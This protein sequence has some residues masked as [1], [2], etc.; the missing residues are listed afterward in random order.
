[1]HYLPKAQLR[2]FHL[3]K[4]M[5]ERTIG[6]PLQGCSVMVTR[7]A[8]LADKLSDLCAQQGATVIRFPCM[9]I[10]DT[11]HQVANYNHI[12]QLNR[13]SLLIFISRNAVHYGTRLLHK[14]GIYQINI[15][16][17]AVG[18]KT[19]EALAQAGLPN[20]IHRRDAASSEALAATQFIKCLNKGSVLIFRGCGGSPYLG[21]KLTRQG[22]TVDYAEV[23]RRQKPKAS[24]R[25]DE[26]HSCPDI[27]TVASGETLAN[28]HAMTVASSISLLLD[29]QL[30]L[31]S[32]SMKAL[33][34]NLG[35]KHKPVIARSPID[36]DMF[37]AILRHYNIH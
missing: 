17:A 36:D 34:D 19:A 5:N 12:K 27:I 25:L 10:I 14:F 33:H 2:Y 8:R 23:Y 37:E 28:L 26:K 18:I 4:I 7:P 20:A 16:I 29:R 9:D 15:P 21:E 31:G 32:I 13:Y 11:T 1:M 35:F 22:L 30:V 24:L 3:F 6:L